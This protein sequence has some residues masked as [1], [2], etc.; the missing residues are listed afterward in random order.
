MG[1]VGR[2]PVERSRALTARSRAPARQSTARPETSFASRKKGDPGLDAAAEAYADY[3]WPWRRKKRAAAF[4]E[5]IIPRNWDVVGE[6]DCDD[7]AW[8]ARWRTLRI[9]TQIYHEGDAVDVRVPPPDSH[10]VE[11]AGRSWADAVGRA[12][13]DATSLDDSRP[14]VA[15]SCVSTSESDADGVALL[16]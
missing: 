13:K 2:E 4:D 3:F 12:A 1:R 9:V 6:G 10:L 15:V 11:T 7:G 16:F 5:D 14:L 8:R